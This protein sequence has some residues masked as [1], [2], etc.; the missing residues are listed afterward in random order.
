V[1]RKI[2]VY[3]GYAVCGSKNANSTFA[4]QSGRNVSYS[5]GELG[6]CCVHKVILW[7]YSLIIAVAASVYDAI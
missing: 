3:R 4:T 5:A 2:S 7:A 6:E 1:I